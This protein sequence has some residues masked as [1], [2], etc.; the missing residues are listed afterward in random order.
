M[1][2][3]WLGPISTW[4]KNREAKSGL[5]FVFKTRLRGKRVATVSETSTEAQLLDLVSRA[6]RKLREDLGIAEVSQ[7]QSVGIR[8]AIA[9]QPRSHAALLR[10]LGEAANL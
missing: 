7:D 10:R 8:A 6:G 9:F 4:E 3:S 5:T 1:T 2:S